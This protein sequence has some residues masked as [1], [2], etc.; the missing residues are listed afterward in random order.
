LGD[1]TYITLASGGD[2]T[3][4]FSHEFQTRCESG[5]DIIFRDPGSGICYNRE[6]APSQCPTS[7]YSEIPEKE[8]QEVETKGITTVEKLV[9][10]MNVPVERTTKTLFYQ[11]EKGLV[12]AAVRGDYE[13]NEEK[14][15]KVLGANR[16]VMATEEEIRGAT[17]AEIG[18]AGLLGLPEGTTVVVDESLKGIRNLEMGA[19]K[20]D[21]HLI[22]VNWSRDLPKPEKFYD[23]KLAKEG[24]ICPDSGQAYEVFRASE[25]GNIFPLNTKFSKAFGFYYTDEQGEKKIVYM[26]SYGIGPSRLMGVLVEKYHDEHGII[27]PEAVAPFRVHL[28]SLKQNEQ[29]EEIYKKLE[30][31]GIE[32]LFDDRDEVG[33]GEKFA[34]A[35]LIGCPYRVVVST[36]SIEA[37]GLEVKKRESKETIIV[38]MEEAVEYFNKG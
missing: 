32:V 4:D 14:L 27:W 35:D 26:G 20:T 12:A 34:E 17:G 7:Q 8:M 15:S 18:F 22:N 19:N 38:K 23:I 2:F 6:V 25:V 10:F 5:E 28:I 1:D 30:S 24:D 3:K 21:Y 13:I 16:L 9:E 37:G 36:K 33:A 31:G 11:S 29:A